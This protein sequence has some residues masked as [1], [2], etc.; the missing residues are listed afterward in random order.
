MDIPSA[1]LPQAHVLVGS[2]FS[3]TALSHAAVELVW[4]TLYS[5]VVERTALERWLLA[6]GASCLLCAYALAVVTST[7]SHLD[8][9]LIGR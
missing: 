2:L 6:A 5:E 9:W 8:V 4:A 3:V 1:R 7:A